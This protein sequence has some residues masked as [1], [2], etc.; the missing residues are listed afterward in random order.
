MIKKF[1]LCQDHFEEKLFFDEYISKELKWNA[2]PTI[3][4]DVPTTPRQ[5]TPKRKPKKKQP[6]ETNPT[7]S[8]MIKNNIDLGVYFCTDFGRLGTPK[9]APA[10]PP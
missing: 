9:P 6:G 3:F 8:G 7:C 10:G 2:V 4:S 1:K 5:L